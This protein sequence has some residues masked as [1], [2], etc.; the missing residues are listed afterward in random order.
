MIR[1]ICITIGEARISLTLL[2][3][4]CEWEQQQLPSQFRLEFGSNYSVSRKTLSLKAVAH[5]VPFLQVATTL[6]SMPISFP[7]RYRITKQLA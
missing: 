1:A 7:I 5:E 6:T 3:Q 4:Y 2:A